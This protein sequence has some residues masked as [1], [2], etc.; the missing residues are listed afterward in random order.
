MVC[1]RCEYTLRYSTTRFSSRQTSLDATP[2]SDLLSLC[3]RL[4]SGPFARKK[5]VPAQAGTFNAPVLATS[6]Y[7]R[8]IE[9]RSWL[10]LVKRMG[11][12]GVWVECVRRVAWLACVDECVFSHLWLSIT[13]GDWLDRVR[14][15][16]LG[17]AHSAE[18]RYRQNCFMAGRAGKQF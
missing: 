17:P 7:L 3:A 13:A 15:I 10:I 8:A 4:S 14:W 2:H 9:A 16:R 18:S 11:V 6:I 12:F 5:F 1:F